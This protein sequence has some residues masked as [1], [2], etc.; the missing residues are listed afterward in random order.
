M[1]GWCV[2][3]SVVLVVVV[4]V[5]EGVCVESGGGE[6]YAGVTREARG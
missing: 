4:V 3:C 5:V 1:S 2:L 6:R